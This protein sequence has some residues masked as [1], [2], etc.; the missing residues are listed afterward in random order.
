MDNWVK[1]FD[2]WDVCDQVCNDLF[3]ASRFSRQKAIEWSRESREFTKR[4]GFTLM[5][6]LAV[7]DKTMG[8]AE[9]NKFLEIIK[10]EAADSRNYVRKAINWALRQIG[11]RKVELNKAAIQ[12]AEVISERDSKNA[13][14]IASDAIRE[15]TSGKI[16]EK[17]N[18]KEKNSH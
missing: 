10:N 12:T 4:A 13:K 3:S 8:N 1:D 6:Q 15:L 14:W 17:L 18:C 5:A 11:K 16:I 2:S 7:H 9:F